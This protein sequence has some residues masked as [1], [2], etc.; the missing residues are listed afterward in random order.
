MFRKWKQTAFTIR[1]VGLF[2]ISARSDARLEDFRREEETSS[3]AF[4]RLYAEAPLNDPWA[5]L[6]PQYQYQR[7][8]YVALIQLLQERPYRRALDLGCGLGLL[9]E[10]LA[11][12]VDEILGID[13]S[14]VALR[15]AAGRMRGFSNVR[16][17]QGDILS[18]DPELD[19][20]FDLIVVADTIYYLPSPIRDET[21]KTLA[22]RLARLLMPGGIILLVNHYFPMPN[23]ESRLTLRIHR[24]FHWSPA[25]TPLA[26]HRRA[27]FLASLFSRTPSS[28]QSP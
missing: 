21:L 3:G 15:C 9:T 23:A 10:H 14:N 26:E 7:R 16:F 19:G 18:L 11:H 4:D 12:R 20:T 24:A 5:S 27:F 6:S 2:L 8:K 28:D 25:L 22:A 13:I 1:D 17:Q